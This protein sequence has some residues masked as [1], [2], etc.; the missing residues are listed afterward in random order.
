MSE[1]QVVVVSGVRTAVGKYGGCLKDIPPTALGTTCVKEAITRAGVSPEDVE[2]V[3]FGNVIHTEAKDMYLARVVAVDAGI[4]YGTPALTVNR[5]CGSGLQAI[6]SVAQTI[7]LGDAT[8]G[9]GGGAESM[10][11]SQYWVPGLR[12]GQ[13]MNNGTV[14]D[15]MVGALTDPFDEVHM[16]ITAENVARKWNISREDQ[17]RLAVEGHRRA[18]NAIQQGIFKGQIVPIEIPSKKGTVVVDTDEQPRTGVTMEALA[19]L[20]PAFEKT[21]TVT[22]G[23]ASSVNDGAGAVV[24]MDADAAKKRGLKPMARL[25]AGSVVGGR[26]EVHGHR[27]GVCHPEGSR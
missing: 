16:G 15:A 19:A 18:N 5:L 13:R 11:R 1:R 25:L 24:L 21:G 23:N 12:W 3:V 26:S 10:S 14:V 9:V 4:P 6:L 7:L 8:V 20:K 27:S 17:D 2:Q 22:A